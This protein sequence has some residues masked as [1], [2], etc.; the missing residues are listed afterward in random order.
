MVFFA[1]TRFCLIASFPHANPLRFQNHSSE[2]PPGSQPGAAM[3]P[4]REVRP[5]RAAPGPG[6][7]YPP[8]R[9]PGS[10]AGTR[11]GDT[12][13]GNDERRE[14]LRQRLGNREC[15]LRFPS[16]SCEEPTRLAAFA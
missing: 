5:G 12:G 11:G 7:A 6:P 14:I 1:E 8:A 2:A 16:G 9:R 4:H 3:P 10:P 13:A 15:A